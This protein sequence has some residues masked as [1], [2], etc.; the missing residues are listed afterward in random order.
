MLAV[1]QLE[2]GVAGAVEEDTHRELGK[3]TSV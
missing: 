1:A 2:L 3:E